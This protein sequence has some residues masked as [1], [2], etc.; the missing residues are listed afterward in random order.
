MR[1][2]PSVV[3]SDGANQNRS[4]ARTIMPTIPGPNRGMPSKPSASCVCVFIQVSNAIAV[5]SFRSRVNFHVVEKFVVIEA[6]QAVELAQVVLLL[7]EDRNLP[8][9]KRVIGVHQL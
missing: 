5:P 8:V 9:Q 4:Q 1:I 6:R 7:A 3:G 2:R